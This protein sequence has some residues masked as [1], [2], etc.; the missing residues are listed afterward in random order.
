MSRDIRQIVPPTGWRA[1]AVAR[2]VRKPIDPEHDVVLMPLVCFALVD[3][4]VDGAQPVERMPGSTCRD[5][6]DQERARP[7][8]SSSAYDAELRSGT[9][10][11]Q[12]PQACA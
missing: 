8:R 1:V 3:V 12:P 11:G 7:A 2:H 5:V 10:D 9:R 6:I 4:S